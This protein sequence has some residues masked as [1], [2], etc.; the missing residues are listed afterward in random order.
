MTDNGEPGV[1]D[2]YRIRLSNG[3]TR[4]RKRSSEGTSSS[5]RAYLERS[6]RDPIIGTL[7]T[8]EN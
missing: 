8:I 1:A 5:T 2:T 6:G 3:T 4:A 7:V